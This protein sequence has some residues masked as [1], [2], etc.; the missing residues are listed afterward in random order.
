[1][2]YKVLNNEEMNWADKSTDKNS[3]TKMIE[4]ACNA[5]EAQGYTLAFILDGD[6]DSYDPH[7][8]VFH[9]PSD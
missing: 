1:M 9:S 3:Y 4:A 6:K 8:F 7:L 5:M 2:P